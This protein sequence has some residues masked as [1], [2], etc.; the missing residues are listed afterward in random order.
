MSL[1][2]IARRYGAALADVAIPRGE[3]Q[4]VKAEIESWASMIDGNAQLKEV[5]ANPTI[6]QDQKRRLLKELIAKTRVTETTAAFLQVLLKNQ[7]LAQIK[8]IAERYGQILDQ[9]SGVVAAHVTT[10]RSVSEDQ[11]NALREVL[12][13]LTGAKVRLE[14]ETDETIIGGLVARIGSTVFD[15]S[16]ETQLQRLTA[17]MTNR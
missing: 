12:G 6:P 7:R 10:A 5:F 2:T 8:D 1:Q 4:K 14:F 3:Q 15:G 13:K 16:V 11:K 9:R 17:D